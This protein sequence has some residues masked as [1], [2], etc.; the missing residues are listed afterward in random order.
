MVENKKEVAPVGTKVEEAKPVEV[1]PTTVQVQ[2]TVK[3]QEVAPTPVAPSVSDLSIKYGW[4]DLAE[5]QKYI[6]QF[7]LYNPGYFSGE[8][9]ERSMAWVNEIGAKHATQFKEGGARVLY[10]E[11][12]Y[13]RN[14]IEHIVNVTGVAY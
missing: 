9:L 11:R 1:Q 14:T 8:K 7:E 4:N 5:P 3:P 12:F 6:D 10:F 2:E 13:S